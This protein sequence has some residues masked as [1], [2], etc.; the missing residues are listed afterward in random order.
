MSKAHER[1]T[2]AVSRFGSVRDAVPGPWPAWLRLRWLVASL[3]LAGM[4]A[5][6]AL[7]LA[8]RRAAPLALAGA[9]FVGLKGL[10]WLVFLRRCRTRLRRHGLRW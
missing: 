3:M 1:T 7:A 4:L 5:F 10:G 2:S 9:L 8:D 6:V